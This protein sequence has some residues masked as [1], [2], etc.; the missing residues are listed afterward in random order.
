MKVIQMKQS[1]RTINL[2]QP[3]LLEKEIIRIVDKAILNSKIQLAADDVR[4][5]AREVMP[6][7][8]RLI[9]N[10]VSEHFFQLGKFLTDKFKL[11]D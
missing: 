7:L 5:I 10:K 9:A 8:D 3:S 6:D 11:G 2:E 1:K 4:I